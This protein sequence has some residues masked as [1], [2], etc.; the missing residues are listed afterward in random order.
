[1]A[2]GKRKGEELSGFDFTLSP[3]PFTISLF[4]SNG[5]RTMIV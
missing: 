2:N 3:S 5:L 4:Y 1:M